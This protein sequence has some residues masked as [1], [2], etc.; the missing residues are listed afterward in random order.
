MRSRRTI[1]LAVAF[2]L[3]LLL[4]G[5]SPASLTF[6]GVVDDDL[7]ILICAPIRIQS[8]EVLSIGE[9]QPQGET[10][11]LASG[12]VEVVA[13]Q[14][15]VVGQAPTGLETSI[16]F[17]GL[18]RDTDFIGVSLQ[19]LSDGGHPTVIEYSRFDPGL[20][21]EGKWLTEDNRLIDKPC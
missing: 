17:S 20:A 14:V 13:G 21:V 16:P 10:V 2:T 12:D 8:I 18:P 5:C 19:R 4:S 1:P 11:W 6:L 15:A 7:E 3:V 9:S